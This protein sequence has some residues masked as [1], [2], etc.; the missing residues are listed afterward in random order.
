NVLSLKDLSVIEH[1]RE[2]DRIGV[3]SAKIEGRMKRPEY[4]AAAVTACREALSGNTPNLEQLRSVLSRSGFTPSYYDGSIKDMQGVRTKDDVEA[5]SVVLKEIKRLYDKPYKRHKV[6]I[7]LE[8]HKDN[9]VTASVKCGNIAFSYDGGIIP[10]IARNKALTAEEISERMG[11]MGGTV[12]EAGEIT[13]LIDEGLILSASEINRMR[14]EILD[15]ITE[16]LTK[17]ED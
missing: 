13:C 9:P 11:K 15:I 12:F 3:T 6:D 17:K 1:L 8:I 5:A 10:E 14:R 2:L 7:N 16:K 4:V